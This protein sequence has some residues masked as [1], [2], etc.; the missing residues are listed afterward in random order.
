MHKRKKHLHPDSARD[1]LGPDHPVTA[2]KNACVVHACQLAER[3]RNIQTVKK[4]I[5]VTYLIVVITIIFFFLHLGIATLL[6]GW[7]VG[8]SGDK[9]S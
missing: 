2:R 5:N 4:R 3:K 8:V 6:L 9:E 7:S 1:T